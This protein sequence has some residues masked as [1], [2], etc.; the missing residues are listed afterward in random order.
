[1]QPAT[2]GQENLAQRSSIAGSVG[3]SDNP[4]SPGVVSPRGRR[5][6]RPMSG[7]M[8]QT[9][10]G[11]HSDTRC[12]ATKLKPRFGTHPTVLRRG[13]R[14]RRCRW[15]G[16]GRA[17]GPGNLCIATSWRGVNAHGLWR[18]TPALSRLIS[19][20]KGGKYFTGDGLPPRRRTISGSPGAFDDVLINVSAPNGHRRRESSLVEQRKSLGAAVVAIQHD[21]KGQGI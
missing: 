6:A 10:T 12:G 18:F 14:D 20:P 3:R 13:A 4:E 1:M 11:R 8:V 9:E 7:Y 19:R 5:R 21:I 16:C 15:Q 17:K 2:S